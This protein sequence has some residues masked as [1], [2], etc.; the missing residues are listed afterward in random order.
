MYVIS[1]MSEFCEMANGHRSG[2]PK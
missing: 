2:Y 1:E